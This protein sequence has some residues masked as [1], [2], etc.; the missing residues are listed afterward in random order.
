[1]QVLQQSAAG[2]AESGRVRALK[3]YQERIF[4]VCAEDAPIADI[5]TAYWQLRVEPVPPDD[6]EA[7]ARCAA[8]GVAPVLALFAHS[9]PV[10][11]AVDGQLEDYGDPLALLLHPDDTLGQARD[12]CA[13]AAMRECPLQET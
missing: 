10:E 13:A 5:D 11:G 1:M 9:K 8:A 7:E 6:V 2:Y 12:R 4:D 3:I